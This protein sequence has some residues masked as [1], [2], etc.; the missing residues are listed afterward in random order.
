MSPWTLTLLCR[1]EIIV[2]F[3]LFPFLSLH[4][5]QGF[6][7]LKTNLTA[8][9]R[10]HYLQF[11]GFFLSDFVVKIVCVLGKG[12]TG[13]AWHLGTWNVCYSQPA[14]AHAQLQAWGMWDCWGTS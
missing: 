5:F 9:E 8:E 11:V 1:T 10:F 2:P 7:Q 12:Q 3:G 14:H 13:R 6:G 4:N